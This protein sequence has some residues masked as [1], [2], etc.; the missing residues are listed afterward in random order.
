MSGKHPDSYW[1]TPVPVWI[2]GNCRFENIPIYRFCNH[3]G[4]VDQPSKPGTEVLGL[5]KQIENAQRAIAAWPPDVRA[6]MGLPSSGK[7]KQFAPLWSGDPPGS[8]T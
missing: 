4:L 6:A 7:P 1:S 5:A 3:C 2:C 8:T